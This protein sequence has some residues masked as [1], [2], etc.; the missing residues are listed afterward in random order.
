MKL[1]YSDIKEFYSN[2][3]SGHGIDHIERVLKNALKIAETEKCDVEVVRAAAVLHDIARHLDEKNLKG[4]CHAE[5]G[6]EMAREILEEYDYTKEQKDNIIHSIRVHRYSSKLKPETI[7]A[8]I[9]QDADRLDALGA[10]IVARVFCKCGEMNGVMHDPSITPSEYKGAANTKTAINH[11]YEKIL[12][13]KPETFNTSKGQEL[14]RERYEFTKKFLNQ[15]L[16]EWNCK[17]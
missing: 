10:I 13:I 1:K 16:K 11:F 5:K 6:A 3:V 15:F 9:I 8:G 17:I 4:P 2:N 7:E 14:A 12:K